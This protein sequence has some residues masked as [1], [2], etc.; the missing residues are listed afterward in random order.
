MKRVLSLVSVVLLASLGATA[1]IAISGPG[2]PAQKVNPGP[3]RLPPGLVEVLPIVKDSS[4]FADSIRMVDCPNDADLPFGLCKNVL[5]G[6]HAIMSTHL[7]G[8]V[9]VRF[10]PPVRN[11]SHFEISFPQN[12]HG[13]DTV[14][15][16]PQLYTMPVT[17]NFILD[18]L[19][20]ISSG[21]VNLNTGEVS[22]QNVSVLVSNS[23]YLALA[24]A[25]PKLIPEPYSFP[26]PIGYSQIV[27]TQRADGL[28]DLTFQ[29]S[30]FL[31]L[32]GEV[33][34]DPIRI[35]LP[36]CGPLVDCGSIQAKG[37][38]MHPTMRISTV[39][40]K[41]APCGTNCPVLPV[42]ADMDFTSMTYF[43]SLGDNFALNVPQL[44]GL[45]PARSQMSGRV[46]VQFGQPNGKFVPFLINAIPPEGLLGPAQPVPALGLAL[47]MVG[48]GEF[49]QFP[50][51]LYYFDTVFTGDDPFNIAVGE[52]DLT[53]GVVL[54]DF[55]YRSFF[56]QS[57]FN[58][59]AKLNPGVVPASLPFQGKMNF[60][61]GVNGQTIMRYDSEIG[62]GFTGFIFPAPS[63]LTGYITGPGSKLDLFYRMQMMH[64]VDPPTVTK[65]GSASNVISSIGDT[66]SYSY[67]I[68]CSPVGQSSAFTYT[69]NNASKKSPSGGTFTMSSLTSVACTNSRGSSSKVGEYDTVTFSGLGSWGTDSNPH[70]VNAQIS[71]SPAYV[72]ILIDA[73]QASH[74]N[75]KPADITP[76]QGP[77]P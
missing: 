30:T 13:D 9:Q 41:D 43:T 59:L 7:D 54:G 52:V 34:G 23:W 4:Y 56:S 26:G 10:Y 70:L 31:P 65:S 62:I 55:I 8:Y 45:G 53:T 60:E 16:A 15:K 39:P 48:T 27:F 29:G 57:I 68:P 28:L 36:L 1:Q 12:L 2:Q 24:A 50:N 3:I 19:S 67:T 14:I 47:G 76:G 20:T 64:P 69:N 74:A 35:P 46:K 25:N 58:G 21:D 38:A 61:K 5:F 18:P 42:N 66:I 49:L 63:L 71:T 17:E 6:G 37:T 73:A 72:V 51:S 32:G 77:R 33:L 22:N 11:M 75:T 44:G 40:L